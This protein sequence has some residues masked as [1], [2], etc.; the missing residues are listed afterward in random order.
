M[1]SQDFTIN[2]SVDWIDLTIQTSDRTNGPTI[3]KKTGLHATPLSP[4]TS[5]AD[6]NF[7]IRLQD[8]ASWW[9]AERAL[10]RFAALFPLSGKTLIV[11]L[12]LS[13]DFRKPGATIPEL[14]ALTSDLFKMSSNMASDNRRIL[15][16]KK[17]LT[18]GVTNGAT[19][20]RELEALH[21]IFVGNQTDNR[22]QR[23]YVKTVDRSG[24]EK[25]LESQWSSRMENTYRR[26]KD[27]TP[28][29]WWL[30]ED[31]AS[32][33]EIAFEGVAKDFYMRT[34]DDDDMA[35]LMSRVIE[36]IP[37]VGERREK[38]TQ[39]GGTRL[40]RRTT[41]ADQAANRRIYAALRS[42]SGRWKAVPHRY[43]D[44][45]VMQQYLAHRMHTLGEKS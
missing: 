26:A 8:I 17:G 40:Y 31:F 25:L 23:Y 16:E 33:R 13:L 43:R 42:L 10:E 37:Q 5:G 41:R 9:E 36:R 38:P 22:T 19:L 34:T 30:P 39:S 7:T 11:G 3:Y 27:E 44:A 24:K 29:E 32:C 21:P 4:E 28:E 45:T 35:S 12:E 15:G 1:I 20:A 18:R 6:S 14:A 2:A